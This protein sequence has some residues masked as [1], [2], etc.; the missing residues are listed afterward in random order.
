MKLSK[1]LP[2]VLFDKH[3]SIN[4][5]VMSINQLFSKLKEAEDHNP[6]APH[7]IAFYFILMVT[8]KSYSHFVD[9]KSYELKEG[10][11][12][13]VAKNQVHHFT[14][15]LKETNGFAI[16]F[17]HLF[18]D[19]HYYL[20]DN[21]SLNRLFNYHI[22]SP[23]IHQEEIGEDRIIDLA[24][25]L[26]TEHTFTNNFAKAEILA[27]LLRVLLLKAERAK[28]FQTDRVIRVLWLE[29]FSQ[30]RTL[31]EKEYVNSRNSRFYASELFVSYKSLN[32]IVKRLTGKTVK[33]FIDDFVTIEIKRYLISTSLSVKEISFKTGFEEPSNMIKFFKKNAKMTPAN[34]RRQL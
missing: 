13:F 34:F 26:H 4:I 31:L 11:T 28:E 18:V 3:T 27:S 29:T 1:K 23:V 33:V 21:F 5:D 19:K 15:G 10:S 8:G 30:F 9:F 12:L 6:F 7:K 14:A 32:D 22:E 17:N 2:K 20:I 24:T 16:V 25:M